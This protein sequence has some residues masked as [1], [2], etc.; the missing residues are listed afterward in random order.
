[1]KPYYEDGLV[2]IYHGDALEV[3]ELLAANTSDLLLTDP[4]YNFGFDYGKHDDSQSPEAYAAWCR[5]WFDDASRVSRRQLVFPGHGNLPV[6]WGVRKPSSVGC[7]Y[8]P[9][10]P[11]SSHLGWDE[12]EPY[13]YWGKRVGGSSV[14]RASISEQQ[15]TGGHPCPKPLT[16][17][18]LLLAKFKPESVID[19]FLGS[20]TTV[21]AAK[22]HGIPSIGIELEE[23]FCETAAKR[24]SQ[25]TLGL[26][27]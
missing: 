15:A 3:L 16:L 27:A 2:T 18:R 7:W 20:G 19:P 9:G 14:V 5:G 21:V 10:N 4:P 13:L 12:W 23:R 1:M 11:S 6:W 24:C 26:T 22:Y 17:M 25:Q 8:K